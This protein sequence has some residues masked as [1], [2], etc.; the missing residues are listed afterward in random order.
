MSRKPV[1]TSLIIREEADQLSKK[2]IFTVSVSVDRKVFFFF[3]LLFYLIG[4]CVTVA[5]CLIKE[6]WHRLSTK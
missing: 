3:F 4:F 2:I 5:R 1:D 6:L